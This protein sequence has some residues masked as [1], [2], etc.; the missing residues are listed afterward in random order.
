MERK[1]KGTGAGAF[2]FLFCAMF[3]IVVSG[4]AFGQVPGLALNLSSDIRVEAVNSHGA[5]IGY[6][7]FVRKKPGIESV[8][9]TEP[10]GYYA[11]RSLV[12]NAANGD[13][14]RELAGRR[15]TDANSR[16]SIISSTPIPDRQFD[17]AFLLFIPFKIVYGNPSSAN[18]TVY[19]DAARGIQ[20]NIRTFDHKYGDPNK[21]RF[22]NNITRINPPAHNLHEV[23]YSDFD[24]HGPAYNSVDNLRRELRE[25][26]KSDDFLNDLGDEDLRKLLI[27]LFWEM[28]RK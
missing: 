6:N 13:E 11:L 2:R 16:Y 9:L 3:I 25:K 27:L 10:T 7:L 21:G 1:I 8:M 24:P 17:R 20:L 15:L 18:G 12:W 5:L 19:M 23:R 4:A 22:Q 14:R 28:D 26:I